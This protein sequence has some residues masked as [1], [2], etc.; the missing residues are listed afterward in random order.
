L[1]FNWID[2]KMTITEMLE[3]SA[4]RYP[5][6][7]A[8]VCGDSRISYADLHGLSNRIACFLSEKGLKK[9][10]RVGLLLEKRPEAVVAFLGIAAAGGVAFP[11]DYNHTK[12]HLQFVL[13]LTQPSALF[14]GAGFQ[15]ILSGL[16]LPC[17]GDRII[18]VGGEPES[19]Y[20]CWDDIAAVERRPPGIEMREQDPVY[21][22]FTSGTTGIPKC[23]VTTHANIYW[24]TVASA[25]RLNLTEK[26]IH[27]CMFPV[28]GHPHELFARPV[29]LGGT[30]VLVDSISPGVIAGTIAEHGVTCMMA[31]ATIY[32]SL[33]R[34]HVSHPIDIGSLRM[35]ESGGMHTDPGLVREFLDRFRA[36]IVPVWGSTE[37]TGIALA[38]SPDGGYRPG[39]VGQ[40]CPRY[41]AKVVDENGKESHTGE[42]G[43]LLVR[44]PGVCSGYYGNPEETAA[45]MKEGWF[46]T[47]DLVRRDSD[48]YFYFAGRKTRMMKVAGLKVFPTE[49]EDVLHSCPGVAEA[50]VVRTEDSSRGEAPK[51]V[52]VLEDGVKLKD[53]DI[54]AYCEQKLSRYKIPR[55]I[56]F[57]D[58]LPKSGSGKVLYRELE[59]D[60]T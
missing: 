3:Q 9:G 36:P 44:G 32:R 53:M 13:D 12:N 38:N 49:I 11:V 10:D 47:G 42:V 52:V 50:A 54:R 30:L 27:L 33:L 37:T 21:L 56:Q 19:G 55:V 41:E 1:F 31:V 46:F 17:S 60:G 16:D 18:V 58:E 43:E 35:A 28:F 26:D 14:A 25:E 40:P 23:T 8:I 20:S 24:N 57:I 4:R 51:A 15:P 5:D 34:Y 6:R 39:S 45:H 29:M 48:N 2:Q 7:T 59:G 22:N